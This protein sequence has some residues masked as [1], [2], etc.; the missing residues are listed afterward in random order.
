MAASINNTCDLHTLLHRGK[1]VKLRYVFKKVFWLKKSIF[2]L[3]M[4][5][6]ESFVIIFRQIP[7]LALMAEPQSLVCPLCSAPHPK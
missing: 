3:I 1:M 2:L 6:K 7:L 4:E 5:I